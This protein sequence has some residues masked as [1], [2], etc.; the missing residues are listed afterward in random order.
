MPLVKTPPLLSSMDGEAIPTLFFSL[1]SIGSLF[2]S[3]ICTCFT[4]H[5]DSYIGFVF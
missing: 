5:R 3:K 1:S 4:R 2:H